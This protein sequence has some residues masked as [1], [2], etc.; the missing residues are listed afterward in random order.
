MLEIGLVRPVIPLIYTS[1][2]PA[3]VTECGPTPASRNMEGDAVCLGVTVVAGAGGSVLTCAGFRED[4]TPDGIFTITTS[5]GAG[6]QRSASAYMSTT[7]LRWSD[8]G[9]LYKLIESTIER[10]KL[11]QA[12]ASFCQGSVFDQEEARTMGLDRQYVCCG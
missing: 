3:R 5:A 8:N 2:E 6:L 9:G 12:P 1:L 7:T 11:G 10:F 4:G